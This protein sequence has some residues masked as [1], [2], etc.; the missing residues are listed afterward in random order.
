MAT[1]YVG[2]VSGLVTPEIAKLLLGMNHEN[3]PLSASGV[4]RF[5]GILEADRW[6]NTGEPIIVASNGVLS[7]G[8]HRLHAIVESGIAAELDVR[9]GV[10]REAFTST[11]TGLRRTNGHILAIAGRQYSTMQGAL[12]RLL[13]HYDRGQM[14]KLYDGI[15]GDEAVRMTEELPDIGRVAALLRALRFKPIKNG[16]FGFVLVAAAREIGFDKAEE[17]AKLVESG[18][19]AEDSP[20]RRLHVRLMEAALSKTVRLRPVDNC[21]MVVLAWNAWI[22]G[23]PVQV[24][25]VHETHRTGP[26]FPKLVFE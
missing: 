9:F 15:D 12:C 6:I 21:V 25:R 23:K 7:D 13:I 19:G 18:Q 14:Q 11:G 22:T 26:G 1:S 4:A 2:T 10:P 16:F 24:L 17:F 5:V 20:T 3:R 8:Q